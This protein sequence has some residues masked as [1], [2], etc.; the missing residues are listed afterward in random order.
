M[1]ARGRPTGARGHGAT[2][3]AFEGK[4][5]WS[6]QEVCGTLGS[7]HKEARKKGTGERGWHSAGHN[8]CMPLPWS[9]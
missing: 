8:G 3:V 7:K 4:H 1:P 6:Q 2:C 9:P 5:S